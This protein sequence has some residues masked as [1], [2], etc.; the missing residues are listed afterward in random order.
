MPVRRHR[1]MVVCQYFGE[2]SQ[3]WIDRQID[4]F[5]QLDT[6]VV[7]WGVVGDPPSVPLVEI[8]TDPEPY[9]DKGRWLFRM[10]HAMDWNFFGAL[11]ADRRILERAIETYRP[12]V[13]LCHFG[14][15]G[16]RLL[17][18]AIATDVPLVV[19]FHGMD[20]SSML[21]KWF[22]RSSLRRYHRRF[23]ASVVVGAHQIDVMR[24]LG[25]DTTRT[26]LIPC[27]VPT[28]EFRPS[29]RT[30]ESRIGFITVGRLERWK[31]VRQSI[32]AFAR[33]AQEFPRATLT[34]VGDGTE[35]DS[36]HALVDELALRDRIR[37]TG[38][39]APFA[40][41]DE[42]Q[43]ADV[44]LHHSLVDAS[45]WVEGFGVSVAEASAMELPIV[46]TDAGGI[47]DQVVDGETGLL[48][49]PLDVAAMAAAMARLAAA[50]QLRRDLG[51]AGRRRMIELFDTTGQIEKLERVLV[52]VCTPSPPN[53][54]TMPN[55]SP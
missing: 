55:S 32:L 11:G 27:G 47:P 40:V 29:P 25:L 36:L 24:S 7:T 4:G 37:F 33:I 52:S 5:T 12:D 17:P 2:P 3:V 6:I 21:T 16:L 28:S 51:A 30:P 34:V 14:H 9:A 23:A 41:R 43:S 10:R 42:L 20:L 19:H 53:G 1:L 31:G 18:L 35:R 54:S 26:H 8:E 15:V 44:F 48:V 38:V 39:L 50:P 22:Y 13:I 45:G 46:A 49:A